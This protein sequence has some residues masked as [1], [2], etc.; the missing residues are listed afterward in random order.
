MIAGINSKDEPFIA[1]SDVVGCLNFA[2]DFVVS[3]TA[4]DKLFGMAEGLWEPDLV[5]CQLLGMSCPID[6]HCHA[7]VADLLPCFVGLRFNCRD[8]RSCLRQ[9]PR[10]FSVRLSEMRYQVGA[11]LSA[12]CRYLARVSNCC[13]RVD[14]CTQS[15]RRV[16]SL[17]VDMLLTF[18]PRF[19]SLFNFDFKHS[20]PDKVIERTLKAR[21]D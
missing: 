15:N 5:S 13:L 8:P 10:S 1:A 14:K 4:S 7:R 9:C 19:I 11:P 18:L 16:R 12:S 17:K 20:T 6:V 3:G 2:K 21:M